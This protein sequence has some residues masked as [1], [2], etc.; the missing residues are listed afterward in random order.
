MEFVSFAEAMDSQPARLA[1]LE[2]ELDARLTEFPAEILPWR[3]GETVV[4][5]AM[6]AA[7]HST[8]AFARLLRTAGIR[9][10]PLVASEGRGLEAASLGDHVVVVSESGRSPEPIEFARGFASG[11]RTAI[12]N[13]PAAPVAEIADAVIELGGFPDSRAYTVGF[14]AMLVAYNGLAGALGVAS[15]GGSIAGKVGDAL[16]RF[17]RPA[18]DF[19]HVLAGASS[20]DVVGAGDSFTAAA[21]IALLARECLRIPASAY[22][23]H[24]YL[25]GPMESV[26]AGTAVILIGDSRERAIPDSLHGSG[27][28][29]I[30]IGRAHGGE[31]ADFDTDRADGLARVAVEVVAGQ[32]LMAAAIGRLPFEIEEFVHS[33]T[34]TKV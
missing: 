16:Q 2:S 31:L 11:R 9:A 22:P 6:G 24:Q 10:L 29:C 33:Q 34:D 4:L 3:A 17:I 19:A 25:H 1:R 23:T 13:D 7:H 30:T 12:T 8:H 28:T 14:T 20:I 15:G 5:A 27:A 18:E 21:E 32:R 26:G